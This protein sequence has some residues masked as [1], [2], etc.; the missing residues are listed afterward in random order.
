MIPDIDE[1]PGCTWGR[2][3]ELLAKAHGGQSA[4]VDMLQKRATGVELPDDPQT[5]ERAI[6]RLGQRGNG[7]GGKYGRWLI[8]FFGVPAELRTAARWMGQYHQRFADLP[9][10]L[11][12]QQL[13]LWDRPPMCETRQ[14]PWIYLGLASVALRQRDPIEAERRLR[15]AR[16]KLP[17]V[18]DHEAIIEADLLD[19]RLAS[20]V[21]DRRRAGEKLDAAGERLVDISDLKERACY[22]ARLADQRAYQLLHPSEGEPD[23]MRALSIYASIEGYD[24]P[25]AHFRREHG[26]AYCQWKLGESETALTHIRRAADFAA[27]GGF[28]RFRAMA[29]TLQAHMSSPE[30]AAPLRARARRMA[31][32]IEQEDLVRL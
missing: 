4:L 8:R 10:S 23:R 15:A 27:D 18:A 20:D 12:R 7:S 14:A 25:F 2:Y 28:I 31:E 30:E 6:R 19:A 3:I 21:K 5:I 32:T 9:S 16:A 13:L 22:G 26:M 24:V 17:L 29:L 11:R 1:Q